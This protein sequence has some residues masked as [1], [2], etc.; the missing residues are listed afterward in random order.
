MTGEYKYSM[1]NKGRIF[2]PVKLREEL[3]TNV[4]MTVSIEKCIFLYSE[5]DWQFFSDTVKKLDFSQQQ[6]LRPLFSNASHVKL[7]SQG[8]ILVPSN[9]RKRA[10]LN[11]YVALVG[12]NDHAEIWD[13]DSW[14]N[15]KNNEMASLSWSSN[16][17]DMNS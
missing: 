4:Y 13:Y 5:H 15:V 1:D 7:D 12:N 14:S 10:G 11:K 16:E 3:G 9:I 2:I 8:R 6:K 17:E